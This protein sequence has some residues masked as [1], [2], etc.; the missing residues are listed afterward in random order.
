MKQPLVSVII[1]NYNYGRF[2]AEAIESVLNQDYK[3]FE[4]IIVDDG[5]SDESKEIITRY[6]ERNKNIIAVFK[7]NGGQT[8]AFNAGF[9]RAKGDIIAFLD[10]DDY[11]FSDKLT[12]IVKK[13][14]KYDLVQHYLSHNGNGVYRHIH[15]DV[16]WHEVLVKYGY[17]YNHSVCSSL[18]FKKQ[19]LNKI[20]PLIDENEM[21]YCTDGI[22]L[23]A[24]LSLVKVGI[25]DEILGFY[26]V[27]GQ[28]LFINNTDKGQKA[29]KILAQQHLYVNKQ[30][31]KR[32]LPEINFDNHKYFVYLINELL[33]EKKLLQKSKCI[34][35]G[36]ETSGINLTE[37][38]EIFKIHI[39]GYADSDVNKQEELF[40]G[41]KVFSPQV[42]KSIRADFDKIIIA[43]SAYL[44][45]SKTLDSI[46][47]EK[48][49]DYIVLPI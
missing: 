48:D 1:D 14:K 12:K 27:H 38:L 5:S 4:L 22:L 29:R 13:H 21:V 31:R 8:S 9:A 15:K 3:N 33:Q 44:A 7:K 23:M 49:T 41:K 47:F 32:S 24:S 39:L 46:G 35:Y 36:T 45:I 10:S 11:W 18:S 6:L 20:F 19:L 2:I 37:V 30:L 26:R 28:N 25:I 40:R 34:I 16:D 17:L 42:L 43:S